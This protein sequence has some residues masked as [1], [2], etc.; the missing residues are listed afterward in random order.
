MYPPLYPPLQ[1]P[2]QPTYLAASLT[3][4]KPL[5][6]LPYSL[7]ALT[8]SKNLILTAAPTNFSKIFCG[9]KLFFSLTAPK[10]NDYSHQKPLPVNLNDWRK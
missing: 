2:L 3:A 9:A 7:Q 10:K 4:Y 5:L 1:P 6:P 8:A